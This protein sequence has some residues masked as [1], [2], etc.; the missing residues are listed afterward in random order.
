MSVL[1]ADHIS[2]Q[3]GGLR[4]VNDFSIELNQRD[5]FAIIGP[6][7]AG[8][9]TVFN[10]LTGLYQPTEGTIYVNGKPMNGCA[11]YEFAEA[12]LARTFQNIRLFGKAT[13]LDNVKMAHTYKTKYNFFNM[14]TR[15]GNYHSEEKRITEESM[16]LLE[17]FE[18]QD[19][20]D[21]FARNLP[22]GE[23][24]KLEIVRALATEPQ[25]ILLDE[26]AAGMNPNEID[27][28]IS[29]IRRIRDDLGKAVLIIEHHMKMVMEIA[30]YIKVL[31]FGETISEGKPEYV[32][33]D[34][35]V[36]ESYLGRRANDF[37]SK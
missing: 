23:Q 16:H 20:K 11:P 37:R 25:V 27:N 5:L 14:L 3:F 21:F 12:G 28:V 18:L 36:I 34:P 13:V 10:M 6:N 24:R 19:K 33:Q 8:K 7:G 32:Q 22:Y 35:K 26:P 30:E 29:L 9:T 2:I 31:D 17:V 1:K 4:A 15:T